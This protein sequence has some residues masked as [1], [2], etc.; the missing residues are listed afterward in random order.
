MMALLTGVRWYIIVVLICISLIISNAEHFFF[1]MCLLAI[2]MSSLEKCLFRSSAHFLIGLFGFSVLNCMI[3][4]CSLEMKPLSI[5]RQKNY[6]KQPERND[7]LHI[8]ENNTNKGWSFIR[9]HG[10][11]S[12]FI[13]VKAPLLKDVHKK[14]HTVQD[15]GQKQ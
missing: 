4:L 1:F 12:A 7:A 11:P 5:L 8:G 10:V 13:K 6:W 3:C 2:F 15:S 14:S 9:S